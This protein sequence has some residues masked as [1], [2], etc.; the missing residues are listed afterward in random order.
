ML[1][2]KPNDTIFGAELRSP[3]PPQK[4]H[5]N[6]L[7]M[8]DSCVLICTTQWLFLIPNLQIL[9]LFPNCPGQSETS[10]L[11]A[12]ASRKLILL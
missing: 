6:S 3:S 5:G 1:I 12:E 8:S 4:R 2:H 9:G 7:P 10:P 11:V